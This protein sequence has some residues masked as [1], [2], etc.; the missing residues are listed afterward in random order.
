MHQSTTDG[1]WGEALLGLAI[2]AATSALIIT[3]V[4][5]SLHHMVS[6]D[7]RTWWNGTS[8]QEVCAIDQPTAPSRKCYTLPVR[9]VDGHI[10]TIYFPTG[11][12]VTAGNSTCSRSADIDSYGNDRFCTLYDANGARWEVDHPEATN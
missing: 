10:T 8:D 1:S 2:L 9:S 5:W 7:S 6:P 3:A 12:V 4:V 11:G